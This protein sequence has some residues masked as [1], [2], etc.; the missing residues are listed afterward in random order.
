MKTTLISLL[1][2]TGL[3][4]TPAFAQHHGHAPVAQARIG[5]LTITG[6]FARAT[7]PRAPV[8][9]AYLTIVNAGGSDDR[10]IAVTG[11]VGRTVEIHE[12]RMQDGVMSMREMAGGVGIPAGKT[13]MLEPG[14]KHLMLYGLSDQLHA[15]ET[16][17]MVLHFEK[18][19]EVTVTFDILALDARRHPDT[20]DG[21]AKGAQDHDMP[22]GHH[23]D[24]DPGN[25]AGR[26]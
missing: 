25:G 22:G 19:G 26:D 6:A 13:V 21:G 1:F 9:G 2:A 10:L 4:V 23:P 11:P 20:P 8:G 7:L 17:D 15:G 5:P 3:V 12:M 16:F 24:A 18:A 14:G